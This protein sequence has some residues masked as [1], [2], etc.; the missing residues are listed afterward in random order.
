MLTY[1]KTN[2]TK[3]PEQLSTYAKYFELIFDSVSCKIHRKSWVIRL[4]NH[5]FHVI[6]CSSVGSA[7]FLL[8][9]EHAGTTQSPGSN[10]RLNFH[11]R[12]FTIA[13]LHFR[14]YSYFTFHHVFKLAASLS[15]SKKNQKTLYLIPFWKW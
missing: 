1:Q 9:H 6:F 4:K 13:C 15:S 8:Y 7:T 12:K 14:I 11:E 3:M 10:C 2:R 5:K